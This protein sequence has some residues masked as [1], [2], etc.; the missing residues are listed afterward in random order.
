MIFSGCITYDDYVE[1]NNYQ[2]LL[3]RINWYSDMGWDEK[4]MYLS[5][6]EFDQFKYDYED[7]QEQD[8]Q[9]TD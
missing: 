6:S 2:E 3:D 7:Q 4:E 9:E 5:K 1:A 8:E